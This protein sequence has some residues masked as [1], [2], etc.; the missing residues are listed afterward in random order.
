M[1][2]F[3]HELTVVPPAF[4]AWQPHEMAASPNDEF[5]FRIDVFEGR[6]FGMEPQALNC[7]ATFGGESKPTPFSVGRDSHVWDCALQ[8]RVTRKQL[9]DL[10]SLGQSGCKVVLNARGRDK[11]VG[12]FLLDTRK[13]KLNAQYSGDLDGEKHLHAC[14]R[15]AP[16]HACDTSHSSPC[17]HASVQATGSP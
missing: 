4:A 5:I 13:A 1:V 10:S 7:V 8:W 14:Q 6:G 3:W 17:M 15:S 2:D 9:R 11:P 16:M 12:W